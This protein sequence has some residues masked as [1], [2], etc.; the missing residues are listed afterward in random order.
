MVSFNIYYACLKLWSCS[1]LNN[2]PA[3]KKWRKNSNKKSTETYPRY[4]SFEVAVT[5]YLFF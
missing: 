3:N 4:F 2:Q 1:S 5:A